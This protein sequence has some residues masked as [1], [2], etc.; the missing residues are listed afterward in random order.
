MLLERCPSMAM[1]RPKKPS[2]APVD[3]SATKLV[4]IHADLADM[5]LWIARIEGGTV[6][7]L[8]DPLVRPQITARFKSIEAEVSKIRNA[9]IAA[10]KALKAAQSKH[11]AG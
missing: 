1:G 10:D 11:K 5:L 8:V 2:L 7:S 4:R 3:E 9:Q 6:A